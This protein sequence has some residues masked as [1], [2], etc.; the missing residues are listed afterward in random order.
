MSFIASFEEDEFAVT[1]TV[2]DPTMG[3][4]MGGGVYPYMTQINAIAIPNEGYH[5]VRWD[6]A[7]GL[8]NSKSMNDTLALTVNGNINLMA[9][10]AEDEVIY[11]TITVS[12]SNEA[13]GTA[14]G[15][16]LYRAGDTIE[17][18]AIP[19]ANYA[20][21]RWR[22]DGNVDNPR[23]I[24]VEGD[25][26]YTAIFQYSGAVSN[27]PNGHIIAWCEDGRLFVKGVENHDV[28]I[29]DMMGRVIYR[30]EQCLYDTFDIDVPAEGIYLVHADGVAT[31][32]VF[33]KK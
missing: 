10:F 20:F 19:N 26:T 24:V 14:T 6:G 5:F 15:G 16:G 17:I 21:S 31:K 11:Y 25:R 3:S 18:Q 12:T 1:L 23:T 27:V 29:T 7:E 33:V 32:K 8:L 13:M 22:E 2:N 30:A 28:I 4:V 9:V